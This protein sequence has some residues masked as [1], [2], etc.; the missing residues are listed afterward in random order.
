MF[1]TNRRLAAGPLVATVAA[2]FDAG[3]RWVSLR[4]KDLHRRDRTELARELVILGRRFDATVTV[5]ADL[6]A[7]REA[8]AAGIHLPARAEPGNARDVL[9]PGALVGMSA[10]GLE[11]VEWACEREVD[12]ITLSPV[13]PSISKPGYRAEGGLC[14]L[15]QAA[16][17]ASTPIVALGGITPAHVEACMA[18]GARGVA[19]AGAILQ[20]SDPAG[21][22]RAFLDAL[23]KVR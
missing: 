19:T 4:E 20:A 21:V 16:S 5:H 18:A 17:I 23:D 10:H 14:D 12:Y 9:G 22:T 7:A 13:F 1:I 6:D 15:T 8:G 11:E 3:L 2:A